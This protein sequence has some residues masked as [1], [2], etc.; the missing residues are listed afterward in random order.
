[1]NDNKIWQFISNVKRNNKTSPYFSRVLGK[2]RNF[3]LRKTGCLSVGMVGVVVVEVMVEVVVVVVMA[4]VKD[5]SRDGS[6]SNGC[7]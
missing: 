5:G 4:V 1:M 2:P 7:W 3:L 6:S